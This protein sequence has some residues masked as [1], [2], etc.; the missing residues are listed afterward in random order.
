MF[1]R[2][3]ARGAVEKLSTREA[4]LRA[5]VAVPVG[6]IARTDLVDTGLSARRPA[7]LTDVGFGYLQSQ[8]AIVIYCTVLDATLS[9]PCPQL[10]L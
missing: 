7:R 10:V 1:Y 5:A 4:L 6:L 3:M 2:L 8:A 9:I